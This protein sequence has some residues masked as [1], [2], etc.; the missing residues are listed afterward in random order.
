MAVKTFNFCFLYNLNS[1]LKYR[2]SVPGEQSSH[3]P[4]KPGWQAWDTETPVSKLEIAKWKCQSSREVVRQTEFTA[5]THSV[6][7]C[8]D[9]YF[10]T[11][12]SVNVGRGPAPRGRRGPSATPSAP[13]SRRDQRPRQRLPG[14][15]LCP[16]RARQPPVALKR[17]V[18]ARYKL[19]DFFEIKAVPNR[20]TGCHRT[21]LLVHFNYATRSYES[22]P[23]PT[24]LGPVLSAR[25]PAQSPR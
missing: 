4:Q 24:H 5:T 18:W 22:P 14:H 23:R 13:Q 25:A 12:W 15:V 6:C 20:P 3:C 2:D 8:P 11:L 1:L 19:P 16:P 9:A 7:R 17:S 10:C 21:H